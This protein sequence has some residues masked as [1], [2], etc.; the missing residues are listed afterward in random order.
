VITELVLH[1]TPSSG[2]V[3]VEHQAGGDG[4]FV[5]TGA[6]NSFLKI[7][8]SVRRFITGRKRPG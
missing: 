4:A 3:L 7:V 8:M 1:G 2:A 5:V 6:A